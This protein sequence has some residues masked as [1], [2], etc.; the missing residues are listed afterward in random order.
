MSTQ[1]ELTK[2]ASKL[3][4]D[5]KRGKQLVF[6]WD[7]EHPHVVVIRKDRGS[8]FYIGRQNRKGGDFSVHHVSAHSAKISAKIALE[9]GMNYTYEDIKEYDKRDVDKQNF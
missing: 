8:L 9:D 6:R 5:I 1:S 3:V 7:R 4:S 2:Q